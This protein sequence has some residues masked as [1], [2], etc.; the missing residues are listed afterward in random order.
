MQVHLIETLLS[1]TRAITLV[2]AQVNSSIAC[3]IEFTTDVVIRK[4]T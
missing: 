1:I 4:V 3:I 2:T